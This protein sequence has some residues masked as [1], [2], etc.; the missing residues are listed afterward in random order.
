VVQVSASRFPVDH[1]LET[2][3]SHLQR[4][5]DWEHFENNALSPLSR[6]AA[7]GCKTLQLFTQD[8]TLNVLQ[9]AEK[10]NVNPLT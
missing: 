4:A 5:S 10:P 7:I 6:I 1:K 2:A 8:G 3:M 9:T